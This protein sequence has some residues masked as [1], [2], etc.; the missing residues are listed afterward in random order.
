MSQ[1]VDG[2]LVFINMVFKIC[3]LRQL[4]CCCVKGLDIIMVNGEG[5][6]GDGV[7]EDYSVEN[8]PKI[9]VFNSPQSEYAHQV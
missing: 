3:T 2:L 1:T 4:N 5:G 9:G 7:H 8:T 6:G